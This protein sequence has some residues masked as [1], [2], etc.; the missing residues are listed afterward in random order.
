[1]TSVAKLLNG[2]SNNPFGD[3]LTDDYLDWVESETD[4]WNQSPQLQQVAYV[5]KSREVSPWGVLLAL[6]VHQ[7]SL[8]EP[9]VVLVARNGQPGFG[10]ADGKA[11]SMFAAIL[12]A[13]GGGK[14]DV[15]T[16][17]S[18]LIPPSGVM[19]DGTGQG[20]AKSFAETKLITEDEDGNKLENPYYV[21]RYT[22]YSLVMHAPEI[23]DLAAELGREGSKTSGTL[24]K[25]WVGEIT[26]STTGD[27]SRRVTLRPNTYR[28]GGI[29]G[30]QPSQAAPLL[31]GAEGGTPQRW[32]WAPSEDLRDNVQR[33]TPPPNVSFPVPSWNVGG[34]LYGASGSVMPR[35]ITYDTILP[36][37]IWVH[38]S[39]KMQRDI[40]RMQQ[41]RR[42]LKQK[43][44]KAKQSGTLTPEL[45]SLAK[46]SM[47]ESHL[48][49]TQIKCAVGMAFLHGRC[50]PS[51]L[52]WELAEAQIEVSR[53]CLAEAWE[54]S[55]LKLYGDL[56]Q[57]GRE[58]GIEQ[59]ASRQSIDFQ[60]RADVI[61]AADSIWL[62]LSKM[63]QA[64]YQ[65]ERGAS[66]KQRQ[67]I[68]EAIELLTDGGGVTNEMGTP[69]VAAYGNDGKYW[70]V[71]N[72]A[73]IE[74]EGMRFVPFGGKDQ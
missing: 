40:P 45:E 63:P 35:D 47:M 68:D 32:T 18:G 17:A 28:F 30:I 2:D 16:I 44:R 26:G 56:R 41:E 67:F 42:D 53:R 6:Q 5:A 13:T 8:I 3:V 14:S 61:S 52:D 66:K 49:L 59:H 54:E 38:W 9:N 64:K 10:L 36:A 43:V 72:G 70:A 7:M 4:I 37:P 33:T 27:V 55:T 46:K 74:P 1:M 62:K 31:A 34:A 51:D 48:I 60:E 23:D 50:N 65:L 20:M 58:R 19:A 29:W 22:A 12:A 69:K 57:R 25:M 71:Y 11:T 73:I 21:N 15:I 24:R 39:P